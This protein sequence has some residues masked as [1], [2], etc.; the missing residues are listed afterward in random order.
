MHAIPSLRSPQ[1]GPQRW[2]GD[3][4]PRAAYYLITESS[5]TVYPLFL[6]NYRYNEYLFTKIERGC[7]MCTILN[8][9]LFFL[10]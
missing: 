7:A 9:N 6:T 1:R 8:K 2:G 4:K 3:P 10:I 5:P